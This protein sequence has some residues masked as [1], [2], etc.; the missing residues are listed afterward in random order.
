MPRPAQ[1]RLSLAEWLVLCLVC[2]APSH[3]FA[4]ARVLAG[5]GDLGQVWR[6]PKPVVYRSLQR[7]EMLGL[8]VTAEVQP[9]STGPAR[10]LI[11]ATSTG[12]P[13]AAAWLR[14]PAHHNREIRS[15]LLAKLA[16]LER[17]GADPG[18]LLAA[19]REQL[20]PVAQ[21][22][23]ARLTD[24]AGIDRTV[25]LWRYETIT[26]TLRFLDALGERSLVTPGR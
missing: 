23:E 8:V 2:E 9:S 12:R 17:S 14:Q 16:L 1:P 18:P 25:L 7:L 24:A 11:A 13:A 20:E 22:L 26:A 6:V 10:S 3:G 5:D 21:G 4:I 19:Q 15:E